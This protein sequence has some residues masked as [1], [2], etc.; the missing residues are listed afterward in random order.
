[1]PIGTRRALFADTRDQRQLLSRILSDG[2]TAAW[3]QPGVGHAPTDI[4]NASLWANWVSGTAGTAADLAQ[5][6]GAAQPIV[7]SHT[8]TNYAFFSGAASNW[9]SSPHAAWN[10]LTGSFDIDFELF[11]ATNT[12]TVLQSTWMAKDSSGGNMR[13]YWFDQQ[14]TTGNIGF[15]GYIG[16][17]VKAWNSGAPL[18]ATVGTNIFVRFKMTYAVGGTSVMDF[19]TSTDGVSWSTHGTQASVA[20]AAA[21]DSDPQDVIIGNKAWDDSPLNGGIRRIRVYSSDRDAGGTLTGDFNAKTASETSTNGATLSSGG[22]TF[23]LVNTGATPA[24]IVGSPQLLGNGSA[25]FMQ[26]GA[27][28]L[29]APYEFFDVFKA[30]SWTSDDVLFDGRDADYEFAA[31]QFTGTP[32]IRLKDAGAATTGVSPTLNTWNI[33][34]TSVAADGTGTIQLNNGT[35]VTAALSA[36]ALTGLTMWRKGLTAGGYGNFQQK[37]KILRGTVSSAATR[38]AIQQRLAKLHGITL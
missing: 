29:A 15:I 35:P 2:N 28:A 19:Y 34:Y 22:A 6:T 26:S 24:Q 7:L 18:S 31:Q 27:F 4:L 8:G 21:I 30:I 9:W 16:D 23:T 3:Y 10:T 13:D 12:P 17:V 36:T 20:T 11:V 5:A 25:H 1:M 38:L 33:L 14:V 32:Q 37:D